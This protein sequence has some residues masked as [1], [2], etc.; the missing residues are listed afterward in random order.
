MN[1]QLSIKPIALK[2]GAIIGVFSFGY[3]TLL[4][5]LGNAQDPFL[6]YLSIMVYATATVFAYREYRT[7]N[8]EVLTFKIGTRLGTLLSFIAAAIS[9]VFNYLYIKFVDDSAIREALEIT[10][11]ALEG[12]PDLTDEQFEMTVSWMETISYSVLP[13]LLSIVFLTFLGFL[14]SMAVA[15]MMKREPVDPDQDYDF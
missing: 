12:N 7:N 2:Y 10:T 5:Y 15:Q 1:N 6:Q 4:H 11:K 3:S 9:S 8:N 13:H 14:F